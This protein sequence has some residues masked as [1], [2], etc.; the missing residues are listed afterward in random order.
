[1]SGASPQMDWLARAQSAAPLVLAGVLAGFTWWLVVSSP[2]VG[3]AARPPEPDRGTPDYELAHARLARFDARGRLEAVIDGER[4]RH[5]PV[6]QTVQ[7]DAM[8]LAL[9]HPD[10]RRV[11]AQAREGEWSE[12]KGLASL[13]GQADVRLADAA[14]ALS[15]QQ[16]TGASEGANA[17]AGQERLG[18]GV[19][20][21]LGERL[22]LDTR[23]RV[24]TSQQ[25]VTVLREGSAVRAQTLRHDEPAGLTDLGGRVHGSLVSSPR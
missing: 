10:G 12:G 11:L 18:P 25:A 15:A 4:M 23:A 6:T 5:Y 13:V 3:S 20:Q 9:R 24:L 8:Q 14:A 7:I 16:A 22:D 19:T 2:D 17:G 21:I 1:M